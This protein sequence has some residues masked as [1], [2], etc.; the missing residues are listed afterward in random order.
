MTLPHLTGNL[1]D[2]AGQVLRRLSGQRT[3]ASAVFNLS[4]QFGGGKQI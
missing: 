3:E 2:L 4:T 1:V